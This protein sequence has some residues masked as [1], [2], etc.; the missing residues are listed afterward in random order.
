MG[1]QRETS[2]KREKQSVAREIGL[3]ILIGIG[4]YIEAARQRR[5]L[6]AS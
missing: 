2:E 4:E 1:G 5:N 6:E 3:A